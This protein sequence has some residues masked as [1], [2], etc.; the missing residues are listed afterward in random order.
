[1]SLEMTGM[2]TVLYL[3]Y[4]EA[5][6]AAQ[7]LLA[8]RKSVSDSLVCEVFSAYFTVDKALQAIQQL[9][10]TSYR[11]FAQQVYITSSSLGLGPVP[12]PTLYSQALYHSPASRDL[13]I[14]HGFDPLPIAAT[15]ISTVVPVTYPLIPE[16]KGKIDANKGEK[17]YLTGPFAALGPGELS[18][19]TLCGLF[20]PQEIHIKSAKVR[21]LRWVKEEIAAFARAIFPPETCITVETGDEKALE[22]RS[23]TAVIRL[24]GGKDQWESCFECKAELETIWNRINGELG[25]ETSLSAYWFTRL[26]ALYSQPHRFYH[27]L[28]HILSLFRSAQAV[29]PS[30]SPYLSLSIWFH[31]AIY[32]PK[33]KDNEEKSADLL[34]T[35][36][37]E[38][39]LRE[40]LDRPAEWIL[41]TKRHMERTGDWE[42]KA[43]MDLDLGVLGGD[44]EGY[45]GYRVGIYQE[46]AWV[47]EAEYRRQ[48]AIVLNSFLGRS[49][50]YYLP[51]FQSIWETQARFNLSNEINLLSNP[52]ISLLL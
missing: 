26:C 28:T 4:S 20:S 14:S 30:L 25:V 38:A 8:A 3:E 10:W 51:L 29:L 32:D 34:I 7:V 15:Q 45:R 40:R 52:S 50:L 27:T 24:E 39:G 12:S 16:L 46:Y 17:V 49:Q 37:E 19:L 47:G 36:G 42:E 31:D 5:V 13:A 33:A 35:F 23:G 22:L 2:K 43:L 44:E 9:Y 6:Y 48:R 1:M 11:P 21:S 41:A 18:L